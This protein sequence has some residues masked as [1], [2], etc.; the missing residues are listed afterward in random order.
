MPHLSQP[1]F[2]G[3]PK[4]GVIDI[5]LEPVLALSDNRGQSAPGNAQSGT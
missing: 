2:Y 3:H 5:H 4:I 1:R